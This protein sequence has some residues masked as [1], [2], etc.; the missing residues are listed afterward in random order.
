MWG[1]VGRGPAPP[2]VADLREL[3]PAPAAWAL[4]GVDDETQ[5]WRAELAWWRRVASDAQVMIRSR[6]DGSDVVFGAVAL[7]A[8]DAMLL[9]VALGA[10]ARG[11]GTAVQ[12]VVDALC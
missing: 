8:H 12:E 11:G 2:G 1:W 10:A 3:L 9:N 4:D 6:L 5:L 7:L